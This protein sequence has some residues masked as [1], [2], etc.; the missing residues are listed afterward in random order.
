MIKNMKKL[1]NSLAMAF[2][3]SLSVGLCV[4][5]SDTWDSHY[6][7][8]PNSPKS[9]LYQKMEADPDMTNFVKVLNTTYLLNGEK[10]STRTYAQLLSGDQFLTVFAP[11]NE[12]LGEDEWATYMKE[13]KTAEENLQTAKIFLNNHI[14]RSKFLYDGTTKRVA[15]MS[16]KRYEVSN[17]KI[18]KAVFG[19]TNDPCTNGTIHTLKSKLDYNPN[20]YE[21]LTTAEEYKDNLGKFLLKHTKMEIDPDKSIS[22]GYYNENSE[23]VYADSV[24]V[25]KSPILDRFGFINKEDSLYYVILPKSAGWDKA[26]AQSS[27]NFKFSYH[28]GDEES[29]IEADSLHEYW[30]NC[31]LL[32]DA[33]FNMN[34]ILQP[35]NNPERGNKLVSTLFDYEKDPKKPLP[36]HTYVSPFNDSEFFDFVDTI[37]CSN[38]KI[39]I[40][41][42]WP[43]DINYTY[44]APIIIEAEDE[45]MLSNLSKGATK[46]IATVRS[47]DVEDEV[48]NV[49]T[50]YPSDEHVMRLNNKSSWQ[51][52]YRIPNTLSGW[53][54][55]KVVIAPCNITVDKKGTKATPNQFSCKIT[56]LSEGEYKDYTMQTVSGSDTT[57]FS[58]PYKLDTIT[59]AV[60]N[61]TECFYQKNTSGVSLQF[62]Q[63]TRSGNAY[64]KEVY[65]DCLIVEPTEIPEN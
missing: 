22:A 16:T 61:F 46:N 41:E 38:G 51:A 35:Y 52:D 36:L 11:M 62:N 25:E 37:T 8:D 32:T 27:T 56:Y 60:V 18:E 59:V 19:K 57:F 2:A 26:L 23:L 53:N 6:S 34:E 31:A 47:F 43:F 3:V 55:L 15:M 63:K 45:S 21:Y 29:K 9:T 30:S 64:S 17:G 54:E 12:S 1:F 5:C 65:L 39:F 13:N 49:T 24:M 50:Y 10:P 14:S 58:N 20:I 48:G 40:C 7:V 4:S 42:E 28:E 44:G 33:F